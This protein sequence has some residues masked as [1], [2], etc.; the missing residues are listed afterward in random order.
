MIHT[1][2]NNLGVWHRAIVAIAAL[3]LLLAIGSAAG[4]ISKADAYWT[5]V[6]C[7]GYVAPYGQAGDRCAAPEG[8]YESTSIAAS[9]NHSVCVDAYDQY[10]SLMA[11]WQCSG[12][13][14]ATVQG[15]FG[16]TWQ[17]ARGV[18]RNNTTGSATNI[19]ACQKYC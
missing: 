11:S 3:T 15:Y 17:S 2:E 16:S 19:Y 5:G 7:N 9:G 10:G 4:S 8:N 1:Q 14:G 13:P 18:A 6:F 12:G